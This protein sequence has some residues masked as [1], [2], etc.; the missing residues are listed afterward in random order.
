[1]P[2]LLEGW[3]QQIKMLVLLQSGPHN[4]DNI[5]RHCDGSL[6]IITYHGQGRESDH[7]VLAHSDIV[8]STYHTVAAEVLDHSSPIY[9]IEW[10]RIV[11]DEGK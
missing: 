7:M 4:A 1:M 10:F 6:N 9:K 8:L 3:T 2:V 11:L 5:I